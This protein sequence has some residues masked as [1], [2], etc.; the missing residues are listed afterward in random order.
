M[1]TA[2]QEVRDKKSTGDY[3]VPGDVLQLLVEDG[4]KLMTQL[5]N[6]IYKTHEWPQ[7][8]TEVP[9]IALKKPKARNAATIA[10]SAS[11]HITAKRVAR[12]LRR[13]I[14]RK[15]RVYLEKVSL[16]LEKEKELGMQFGC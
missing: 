1:E 16:D 7:D 5:I 10:Q 15:L 13:R 12:S 9:V 14:E 11:L 8:F 2:I 4:P 3:D 6:N